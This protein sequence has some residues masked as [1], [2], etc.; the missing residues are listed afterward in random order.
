MSKILI[1]IPIKPTLNPILLQK[2]LELIGKLPAAN[3]DHQVSTY[4]DFERVPSEPGDCRPWS[5]VARARNRMV[6]RIEP[7][8]YDYLLWIDADVIDYPLDLPTKLIQGNKD[9]I[10]SPMVMI[11]GG[12]TFYDWAAFILAG[13]DHIRPDY[14]ERIE[15]RNINPNA[16]YWPTEPS[17]QIVDMDCTG[18]ICMVPSWIY[19][20]CKHE[21]HPAFTDW[22]PLA[23]VC[24]DHGKRV[25]VDRSIKAVHAYL[26]KYGEAF[27]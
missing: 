3:P 1:C 25:T 5:K 11:E 2:C 4:L 12:D 26:P 7:D 18:T 14:R 19:K 23:K 9:G 27:H 16:P 10:S 6:S 8:N 24:R 20:H 21:D 13:K 22:F 15:G 17:E